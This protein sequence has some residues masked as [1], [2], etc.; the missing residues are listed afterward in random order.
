VR[1]ARDVAPA[2]LI[3]GI[4]SGDRA[5][6][7]RALTLVESTALV[8]RAP[9]EHFLAA[10]PAAA[11]GALR[12]GVTGAP[13]AGKSTFLEV[14]GMKLI[15][16][17]HRIG[18]LAVDPSSG[19]SGGSILG[20]KTR[21]SQLAREPAAFIRPTPSS[22]ALGG[23]A[24]G[25]R[26]GVRVLEA[27]GYDVVIVETVGVGQSEVEVASLVDTLVWIT[28][29]NAG[30]ELQAIKR[31]LVETVDVVL[32]NKADGERVAAAAIARAEIEAALHYAT[33]ATPGWSPRVLTVSALE[34]AGIDEAFET[35][36][37]HRAHLDTTMRLEP[38]RQEQTV[39]GFRRAVERAWASR[40]RARPELAAIE[41]ELAA[42]RISLHAAVDRALAIP[43]TA[44][45]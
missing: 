19:V 32:V 16:S 37:A 43:G 23:V 25:T 14:L 4:T 26:E 34:R 3:A 30:D 11:S 12:I 41:R 38:R 13:G 42:G 2:E 6:L 7:G 15:A 28:G 22:G 18:I 29:P 9:A 33:P 20:D 5:A 35:I 27:A 8:D 44:G 21:M 36:R 45:A 17:G 24:P 1:R 10:L 31:G 40:L 39:L